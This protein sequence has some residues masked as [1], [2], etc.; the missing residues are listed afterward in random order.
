M[1]TSSMCFVGR[2]NGI[3]LALTWRTFVARRRQLTSSAAT[4]QERSD[5]KNKKEDNTGDLALIKKKKQTR[6]GANRSNAF[7]LQEDNEGCDLNGGGGRRETPIAQELEVYRVRSGLWTPVG[8]S[9]P[10][11]TFECECSHRQDGSDR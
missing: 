7:A 8:L 1:V 4:E 11:A 5:F 10:I 6:Y 3:V 9:T 2:R